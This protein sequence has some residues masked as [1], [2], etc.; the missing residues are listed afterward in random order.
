[1]RFIPTHS[2]I[3]V[4][5]GSLDTRVLQL[6]RDSAGMRV[7][8]A[9]E[10]PAQGD[11]R[12][13][14]A[15]EELLGTGRMAP[16]R[17][18]DCSI[19]LAAADAAVGLVP[20]DSREPA[21][22]VQALQSAALRAVKDPEG[23]QYRYLPLSEDEDETT[24]MRE[25]YLLLT[26]GK[27]VER[28]CLAAAETLK[29]RPVSME[30]GPC[31]VARCLHATRPERLD[32]WGFLHLGFG[33]TAFGIVHRGELRFLKPM[34]LSGARL[35]ELLH[36]ALPED[37]EVAAADLAQTLMGGGA[38]ET[39]EEAA[40]TDA[41]S[42]AALRQRSL[43]QTERI[44]RALRVEAE[45]LAQEV[46]ACLRHFTNRFHDQR[47]E[48]IRLTGFGAG[49]PEIG[50]A[51][52]ASLRLET[53]VARPFTRLGIEAPPHVLAEEHQWCAPL[54]LALRGLR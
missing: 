22:V 51:L 10:V 34:Q 29:L 43:G 36:D 8:A 42:V 40:A 53:E 4:H 16:F 52:T 30:P 28:R 27:S 48:E 20:V 31:A 15:A 17:G 39:G 19:G 37:G 21:K 18:R 38:D 54:G 7:V 23:I 35:L 14:R 24:A 13:T 2:P 50:N 41:A 9:I 12:Q 3:A 33:Q 46:R 44:L 11:S 1:M 25:E 32:P 26:L 45:T 47:V 5:F 6:R 49:L